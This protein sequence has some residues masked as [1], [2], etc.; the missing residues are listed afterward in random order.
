MPLVG[1]LVQRDVPRQAPVPY[2]TSIDDLLQRAPDAVVEAASPAAVVSCAERIVERGIPFVVASG[3]AL[4]DDTF[5]R[6]VEAACQRG[7]TRVYVPAGALAGLDVLHA[8]TGHLDTVS[9]RVVE[10]GTATDLF[11]GDAADG[12]AR[13]P[14]RLNVAA[15]SA[16]ASQHAVQ[17]EFKR[18]AQR[19]MELSAR[20]PFGELVARSR[21]TP[22]MVALSLVAAV[23]RLREPIVFG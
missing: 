9:L 6:R 12:I 21:P 15:A 10:A 17:L 13:Y 23:R 4:T 16:L 2:T 8:V 20:G 11:A 19:E 1:I 5:R 18:A 3:S 7:N 22:L 14:E